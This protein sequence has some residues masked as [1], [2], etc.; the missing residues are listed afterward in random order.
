MRIAATKKRSKVEWLGGLVSM[1]SYVTGEGEP[2]RPEALFWTDS[3][4]TVIGTT[5]GKPGELLDLAA[6]SLRET[7]VRPMF[8]RPQLPERVRV[9]SP[10]LADAL[11]AGHSGLEIVCAPT[12]ELDVFVSALLEKMAVGDEDD[13]SYLSPELEPAAVAAFFR[14]SAELFRAK[15]WTVVPSDDSL[16]SVSIE[17]LGIAD[18]ALLVIGQLGESQGFILFADIEDFDAFVA[19]AEA[20]EE[21]EEPRMPPHFALN[22][23][24]EAEVSPALRREI[25]EQEWEVAGADAYPAL[26]PVDA[27]LVVR[28]PTARDLTVAEAIALGLPRLLEEKAVLTA[29]W[30]G[31]EPV[32]RTIRV[33]TH[34]GEMDLL[35]RVPCEGGFDNVDRPMARPAKKAATR[36]RRNA[37]K[38]ARKARKRNR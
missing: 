38:A 21:G 37:R 33:A 8:G 5:M 15:P 36:A 1:P 12:P 22:F 6:E 13:Q 11:R 3:E 2:Y 14:A 19:A 24:R 32:V 18:A 28:P 10:A 29:A 34:A 9:A 17:Q 25:A 7:I 20:I 23:E 35:L 27:D 26:L 30:D 31:G 4:G 16:I